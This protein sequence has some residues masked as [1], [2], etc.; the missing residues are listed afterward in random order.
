MNIAIFSPYSFEKPGGV[1]DHVEAQAK[2]LRKRGHRVTI[3][4]PRPRK[5]NGVVP[6]FTIFTGVSARVR[7]QSST[8][9]ISG[10][11]DQD[12]VDALFMNNHFDVVHFHEPGV[13][14]V[15]RQLMANCP[16]PVVATLHAAM[17][18][19]P[20]GRT[21]G[22]IKP[23]FR[24]VLQHVDVLTRVSTAA[25]EYLDELLDSIETVFIPNGIEIARINKIKKPLKRHKDT[26]VYIGR[27]EKRKGP[28][29][30]LKAF[31][32][33][34]STH[35]DIQLLMAGDGPER[36]KLEEYIE[37]HDIQNVTML[38]Y[39]SDE[40]KY[41]LLG[42]STI[43]CYPALYGES[44]GIVLLEAMAMGIPIVAGAN[45][46]YETVLQG[47][48]ALGLVDA[49]NIKE[50][51]RKLAVFLSDSELRKLMEAWGLKEVKKYN[52]K[53]IVDEYESAYQR[54]I[55]KNS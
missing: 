11:M 53:N 25:G 55:E 21:I 38:G 20:I 26:I 50:L 51:A 48:G 10:T 18:E 16:Y 43:A 36:H 54:A 35:S 31:A 28:L 29:Y 12:E 52:Y 24:N 1:Q 7:A 23:Y 46:G 5:Y 49:T 15:G 45:P 40:K 33:L 32:L 3:L 19:T 22:S 6:E 4:T 27:L 39:I 30:L 47:R 9:D 34:Q 44:F 17:P 14:F 2:E 42:S 41:E 37:E 13:P 8:V